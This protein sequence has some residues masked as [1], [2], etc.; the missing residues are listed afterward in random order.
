MKRHSVPSP[1]RAVIVGFIIAFLTTTVSHSQP[2]MVAYP[3]SIGRD[4]NKNNNNNFKIYSY[5]AASHSFSQIGSDCTP[6]LSSPGF[7]PTR[8]KIAFNPSDQK[9]YYM[10]SS[11]GSNTLVWKWTPGTC[12]SGSQATTYNFASSNLVGFNFNPVTGSAYQLQFSGSSAPYSIYLR[13][14]NS[15]SPLSVGAT[16]QIFLPTGVKLYSTTGDMVITPTGR[17]Y[18]AY[19]NKLFS[20]DYSTYG[21]GLLQATYID[22]LKLGAGISLVGLAYVNGK[23]IAS[24]TNNGAS[25]IYEEI[26][27]SSSPSKMTGITSPPG[28]NATRTFSSLD[29]SSLVTSI[30][31]AQKISSVTSLGTKNYTVTY[32]VKVKN[33]G[34]ANL[35]NVQLTADIKS[36]F[37]TPFLNASAAAVG[38]LPAGLAINPSFNGNTNTSI[39]KSGGTLNASPQ[40]SAIV[41]ITVNLHN[42]LGNSF[43]YTS[44]VAT[45]T[46]AFF[47]LNVKDSSVDQ[48]ALNPDPNSNGVPDDLG[49]GVPTGLRL[50]DWVVV[51]TNLLDFSARPGSGTNQGVDL[52][53]D[54]VNDEPLK[55]NIQRSSDGQHFTTLAVQDSRVS[56]LVQN[57]RYTDRT[58]LPGIG[59]YR[60]EFVRASGTSFYSGTVQVNLT[61]G[62]AA[63]FRVSP[64]PFTDHF[65]LTLQLDKADRV[66]YKLIDFTGQVL[67][68]GAWTGARGN[69]TYTIDH[70]ERTPPGGYVLQ[71]ATG[72]QHISR[73][74][75]KTRQ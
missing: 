14:I 23:F 15:F 67:A 50:S 7:D 16:Q 2:A 41:R 35:T 51:A 60:L 17:M 29:L 74:I 56:T 68:A 10:V 21:S 49:E 1:Y 18:F 69:N 59:Y 46:G 66:T 44:T 26:D 19:N 70:L 12:P 61:A 57:Y 28:I 54:L 25:C 9:V 42:P 62:E 48:L 6:G 24:A 64:V 37:G 32:D 20:L 71:V 63:V 31:V 52:A 45:A 3:L 30:G 34:N 55:M 47:S 4:C 73:V 65:T 11:T 38:S 8:G 5:S 36:V 53:W 39:F 43:Y 58:P 13:K 27:I 22:T 72:D 40:D 33:Y 75:L